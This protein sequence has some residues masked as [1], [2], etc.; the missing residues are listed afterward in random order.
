MGII[1]GLKR[2][3]AAPE[4]AEVRSLSGGADLVPAVKKSLSF[5]Q[6]T[7]SFVGVLKPG[8]TVAL[9]WELAPGLNGL[10]IIDDVNA[11]CSCTDV[12][13]DERY[14]RAVFTHTVKDVPK[15]GHPIK[16]GVTVWEKDGV[17][18][19]PNGRGKMVWAPGKR[20]VILQFSGM[21]G[22]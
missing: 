10:E 4:K 1:T 15:E 18:K 6:P 17:G 7:I 22:S 12:S 2:L 14:V 16:Y 13:W 21:L 20:N 19:E 3:L 9:E 11:P 8:E 5:V